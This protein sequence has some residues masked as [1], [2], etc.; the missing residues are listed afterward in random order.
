MTMV[1]CR[2]R[3]TEPARQDGRQQ[4][5]R[6]VHGREQDLV[7][8]AALDVAHQVLGRDA[9]ARQ[10]R[11]DDGQ[12]Q[13]K[14]QVAVAD[15]GHKAGGLAQGRII[16]DEKKDADADGR[17]QRLGRAQDGHQVALDQQ[18]DLVQERLPAVAGLGR[19]GC[20]TCLASHIE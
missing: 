6:P 8:V 13:D 17:Q 15:V 7:K 5:H 14:A 16:D 11:G 20:F 10:R 3:I 2:P 1:A 19:S 12:G 4:Q 18:V 9:G